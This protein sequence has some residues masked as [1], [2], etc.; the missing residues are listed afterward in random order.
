M[1]LVLSSLVGQKKFLA[2]LGPRAAGRWLFIEMLEYTPPQSNSEGLGAEYCKVMEYMP[3]RERALGSAREDQAGT[4]GVVGRA[5][6]VEPVHLRPRAMPC[7][8]ASPS[9]PIIWK[10]SNDFARL[11]FVT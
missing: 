5:P 8:P 10:T 9:F 3:T 7:T 2:E 1:H 11:S 4:R 6:T